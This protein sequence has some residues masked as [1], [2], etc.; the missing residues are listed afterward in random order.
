MKD[1][2]NF[3][4]YAAGRLVS[5]TGTGVQDVAVPL[6]ILFTTESGKAMGTFM[7]ITMVPRLLLY[8]VAGVVGD[9]VDRKFIMVSM[10]FGRGAVILVLAVLAA[11]DYVTIPVLFIAQFVLSLMNALFGPAT[12]AMLPDIVDQDDLIRANSIMG[13]INSLSMIVGPILGG[14]IFALGGIQAAF[15]INGVSFVGSGV[16]EFFITYEQKTEKLKKVGEVVSDL[17]EGFFFVKTHRGLLTL[18]VFAS[19][20]NLLANPLFA[21]LAPYVMKVVIQFSSEQ[22]GML[23]SSFVTGL[24]IGNIIIGALLAKSKVEKLLNRGLLAET[25]F[26]F[27]FVGLIFPQVI[28]RFGHGS[29]NLFFA[30]FGTFVFM[31]IFNA[32]INTPILV[33]FQ[34]MV[35]TQYRAR[36]FSVVEVIAQGVVPIGLGVMGFLL[37]VAP[38]HVIAFTVAM[39]E[40][41]VVGL[42]VFKYSKA[43]FRDFSQ[44]HERD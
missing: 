12:S 43:V 23:Q 20:L 25:G 7:I 41:L 40:L 4:L 42:F 13:S 44:E 35:P 3:W 11:H 39:I 29:W 21:V 9:R 19:V 2:K 8:P 18:L 30:I 22:F 16:S 15:I 28:E 17:T 34:K 36:V 26:M 32:F 1:R 33:E 24:L 37:D 38:A 31:G 27:V 14:I 6:F 10:D 5:L